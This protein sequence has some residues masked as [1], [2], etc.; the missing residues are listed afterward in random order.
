MIRSRSRSLAV[1]ALLGLT[2]PRSG[3]A[4]QLATPPD[5]R[6]RL[7]RPARLLT[8]QDVPDSAWRFVAMPPGWHV[9]T[10]PGVVLYH[11]AERAAGRYSLAASFVLFPGPSEHGFGLVLGAADLGSP[12]ADQISIELR[13][14]G[15]VRV[16]AQASGQERE[17]APWRVHPAIRPSV[18][19]GVVTN[20]L[21]VAVAQDSLR[22]FV[23]DSG[24]VAVAATGLR[25]DGQFGLRIGAG[26]NMHITTL[27]HIRHLAPGR[28]R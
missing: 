28:R 8:E 19:S 26:L 11:P 9:T 4:Q 10:G 18:D 15:A 25:T 2:A 21:R 7:D 13:R 3:A 20:Q 12:G 24:V 5:W 17:L 14:D 16:S 22:I 23:N 1:A 27:D 6:W